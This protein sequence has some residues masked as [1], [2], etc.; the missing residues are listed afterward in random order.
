MNAGKN[1]K[2]VV[3]KTAPDTKEADYWVDLTSD[4]KGGIIKYHDGKNWVKLFD[5][6]QSIPVDVMKSITDS[7]ETI[8]QLNQEIKNLKTTMLIQ[9]KNVAEKMNALTNRINK[10]EAIG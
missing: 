8:N 4:P 10:L 6:N 5:D 1:I 2:W 9:N 3:A 7:I